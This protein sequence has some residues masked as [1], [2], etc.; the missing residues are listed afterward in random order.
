VRGEATGIEGSIMSDVSSKKARS[1]VIARLNARVQPLDRGEFFE[2]PLDEAL[3]QANIG[4]VTGGG[5]QLAD[6]P[7]GIAWCEVEIELAEASDN[8]FQKVISILENLKAPKGSKLIDPMSNREYL[9]GVSDG[10]ALFL[11]GTDLPAETYATSGINE[12]VEQCIKVLGSD[13]RL[14]GNWEGS[15][16][17]GLYFYGGSFARMK[18]ALEPIITHHPLCQSCRLEQIA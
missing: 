18:S 2:D 4:E 7:A 12:L 8:A 9:F 15:K 14:L 5:T 16:E 11:N 13:G 3:R 6:E 17:V 10:L 1:F